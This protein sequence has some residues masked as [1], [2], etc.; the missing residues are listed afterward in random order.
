MSQ[1]EQAVA[2]FEQ[3][4]NCAQSI[5]AAFAEQF[6]VERDAALKIS[7]GFGGGMGRMAETCG[8][9]TGAFMVLGLKYGFAEASSEAKATMYEHIQDFAARFRAH[10][11]SLICRELLGYDISIPEEQRQA[12]NQK[13]FSTVCPKLVQSAAV[14]L[15]EM[16]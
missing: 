8:V 11:D 7:A 4:F 13:L 5:C 12:K 1:I 15:E 14:I 6:G 2:Y 10:H 16:L 3:G 9:V